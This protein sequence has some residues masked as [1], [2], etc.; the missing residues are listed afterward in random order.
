MALQ[1]LGGPVPQKAEPIVNGQP[2]R[3][4]LPPRTAEEIK[5]DMA[6]EE[7][8]VSRA[9]GRRVKVNE[10]VTIEEL[11]A[12]GELADPMQQQPTIAVPRP[13]VALPSS[14]WVL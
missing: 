6:A 11:E 10:T 4:A 9:P 5:R 12:R 8:A 3:F 14:E 7:A 1:Q 13:N 2:T